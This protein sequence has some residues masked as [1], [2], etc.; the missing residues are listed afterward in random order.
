MEEQQRQAIANFRYGLIAPLVSRKLEAGEQMTVMREV[1]GHVYTY[2]D[3][4]E[5]K[6]SL[7]TLERYVQAYR[8]GGWDALLPSI[9]ADKLQSREI[10]DDV[11]HKAIALKKEHPG[12]SVRQII[13]ILEL[14]QYVAPGML[15]ESTLSK[16][17]R[18]RGV[19]RK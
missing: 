11:L 7:R 6:L 4:Q 15:K 16:Q 12:R 17:L 5:K 10:A 19:T 9:R 2:P 18:K 14:A 3:G 1:V 13:A 8:L